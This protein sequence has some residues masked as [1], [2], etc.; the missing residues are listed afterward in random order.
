MTSSADERPHLPHD[1]EVL[2][3]LT[4]QV[5]L[6]IQVVRKNL[7]SKKYVADP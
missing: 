1:A 5:D 2:R 4:D 3:R 6:A 7:G